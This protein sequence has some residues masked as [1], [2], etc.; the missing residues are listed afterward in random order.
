LRLRASLSAPTEQV[1]VAPGP[2]GIEVAPSGVVRRRAFSP[3]VA[4]F[5]DC[6]PSAPYHPPALW[7]PTVYRWP[8]VVG[9]IRWQDLLHQEPTGAWRIGRHERFLLRRRRGMLGG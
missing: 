2:W 5:G 8:S 7:F 1:T 3:E 4:R 6:S 9:D